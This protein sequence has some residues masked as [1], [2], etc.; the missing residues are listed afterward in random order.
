MFDAADL[1]PLRRG[2][3]HH[4]NRGGAGA[5]EGSRTPNLLITNQTLC[6]L[7]YSGPLERLYYDAQDLG[8]RV[9]PI[10][11]GETAGQTGVLLC[12]LR[13]FRPSG[14]TNDPA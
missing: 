11:L 8:L 7:S 5:A 2:R 10:N 1:L 14:K 9:T 6:Q 3:P 13:W 12:L 4:R